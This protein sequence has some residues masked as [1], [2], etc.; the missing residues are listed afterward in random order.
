VALS[1]SIQ[2]NFPD[3]LSCRQRLSTTEF[4][5]KPQVPY[6]KDYIYKP[7]NIPLR[8][9]VDLRNWDSRIENQLRVGS[10]TGNALANAY[11]LLINRLTPDKFVELSRLF[12]YY[13]IRLIEGTTDIDAGGY[14]RD[15]IRAIYKYGICSEEEWPYYPSEFA[16]PPTSKCYESASSRSIKNYQRLNG[17]NDILDA[18]NN[19]QPVVFGMAVYDSFMDVGYFNP[20]VP[21]P[22]GNEVSIGGHAMCMVGY[23]LSTQ[24]F[25]A[26]N[27]FGDNWGV[28]GYCWMP[29][30]Y[31]RADVYDVWTF[32]LSDQTSNTELTFNKNI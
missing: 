19:N 32:D 17:V 9:S 8:D 3:K 11:E 2:I 7:F 13:N 31:I 6:S 27:S 18:L 14:I 28:G 10:C 12:I 1:I 29:F 23:N 16:T 5:V 4:N 30:N 25:L 15:G 24:Q 20:V 21:M 22:V 26:K